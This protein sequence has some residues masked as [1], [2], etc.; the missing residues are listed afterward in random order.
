MRLRRKNPDPLL[1]VIP[2]S[3]AVGAEEAG[4]KPM[5]DGD[6]QLPVSNEG[7]PSM[8]T[9]AMTDLA[10]RRRLGEVRYGVALQP[11][12]GRDAIRDAYEEVLD[13]AAYLAQC[14]FEQNEPSETYVGDLIRELAAAGAG[15]VHFASGTF[16]PEAVINELAFW[17]VAVEKVEVPS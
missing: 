5:R 14:H 11:C 4:F 3:G 7:Y 12:N 13:A 15:V 10:L 9:K 1:G 6:Q 16:V 17:G 8:H 2:A